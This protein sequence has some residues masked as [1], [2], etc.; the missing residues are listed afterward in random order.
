MKAALVLL[1]SFVLL[2]VGALSQADE[3]KI[4]LKDVPKAVLDAVRVKYP[5]AELKEATKETEKNDEVTY[6][7][8]LVNQ[9]KKITVSLDRNAKIGEIE[10]EVA[11]VDLPKTVTDAIAAK[12]PRATLKKAEEIVEIENGKEEKEYEVEI[13]TS[14][15]KSMEVTVAANGEIEEG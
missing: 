2:A 11:I 7:I 14:E 1:G 12:Y 5:R 4:D 15:G 9:G 8:S 3:Q 13:V 6:E 10:T